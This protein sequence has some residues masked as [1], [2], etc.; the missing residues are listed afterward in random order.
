VQRAGVQIE[1]FI[2]VMNGD[3]HVRVLLDHVHPQ[4]ESTC[5]VQARVEVFFENEGELFV[6][7][8]STCI[9]VTADRRRVGEQLIDCD[10]ANAARSDVKRR[11]DE[12]LAAQPAQRLE[13]AHVDRVVIGR[14]CRHRL[15]FLLCDNV[16]LKEHLR[17]GYFGGENMTFVL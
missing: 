12:R 17:G 7:V 4:V 5:H 10:S 8:S 14:R 3:G 15:L 1:Y 11:L 2:D 16:F 9:D 6:V 13:R